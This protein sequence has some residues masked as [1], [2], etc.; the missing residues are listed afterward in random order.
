VRG[1]SSSESIISWLCHPQLSH[2]SI[3]NSGD[4]SADHNHY[5]QIIKSTGYQSRIW[6]ETETTAPTGIRVT[7]AWHLDDGV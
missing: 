3:G 6:P 5:I 1:K 2:S 7:G 4:E